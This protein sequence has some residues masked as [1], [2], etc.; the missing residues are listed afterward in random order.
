MEHVGAGVTPRHASHR[1]TIRPMLAR[2][3]TGDLQPFKL[4]APRVL[5]VVR[6]AA[7]GRGPTRADLLLFRE[8]L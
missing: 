6:R 3:T 2:N 7:Q 1:P 4:R 5:P 8:I